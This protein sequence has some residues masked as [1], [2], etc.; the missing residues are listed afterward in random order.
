MNAAEVI[1][2]YER[3]HDIDRYL[4]AGCPI[5]LPRYQLT[6]DRSALYLC[7]Q[8][9]ISDTVSDIFPLKMTNGSRHCASCQ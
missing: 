3:H 7:Q 2:R 1:L 4:R 9:T 6:G 8:T 5:S